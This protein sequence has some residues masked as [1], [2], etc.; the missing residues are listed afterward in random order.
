MVKIPT[1][2]A[3]DPGSYPRSRTFVP[4]YPGNF[5]EMMLFFYAVAN[6]GYHIV[7][8]CHVH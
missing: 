2:E 1:Y 7:C 5:D 3:N 6:F 4:K 8:I